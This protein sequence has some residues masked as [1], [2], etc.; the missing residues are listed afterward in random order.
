MIVRQAACAALVEARATGAVGRLVALLE[1][2]DPDPRVRAAAA[3]AILDLAPADPVAIRALVRLLREPDPTLADGVAARISAS[4]HPVVLA[5][6][7]EALAAEAARSDAEIDRAVLF[8]LFLAWRRTSGRDAGYDP[9]MPPE[10]V[11][12]LVASLSPDAPATDHV[13]RAK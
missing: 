7:R 5:A 4:S 8:R 10:R 3:S 13:P 6:L 11:R 9:S 1:A 12:A 2:P